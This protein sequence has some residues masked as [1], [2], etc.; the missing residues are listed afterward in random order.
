MLRDLKN[1]INLAVERKLFA[2]LV[3]LFTALAFATYEPQVNKLEHQI[4]QNR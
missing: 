4:R 2:D 1:N 3:G